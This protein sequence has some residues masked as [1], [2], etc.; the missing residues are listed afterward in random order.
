MHFWSLERF[1][2][3][4]IESPGARCAGHTGAQL[5]KKKSKFYS[6][7]DLLAVAES[8]LI[9]AKKDKNSRSEKKFGNEV[10]RAKSSV[11][12]LQKEINHL[13]REYD[14]T[15]RGRKE[16]Q[17]KMDT[18]DSSETPILNDRMIKG[19]M[20]RVWRDRALKNKRQRTNRSIRATIIGL[21]EGRFSDERVA[22]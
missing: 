22:A 8:N 5:M 20:Q 14:G 21:S 1:S 4:C 12:K 15:P 3:M 19:K 13:Q 10:K 9:I 7:S 11:S 6:K 18:C 16:L 17:T 2:D